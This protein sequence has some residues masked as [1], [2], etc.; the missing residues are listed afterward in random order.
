MRRAGPTLALYAAEGD[1]AQCAG[2][3]M[4]CAVAVA[5]RLDVPR[6]GTKRPVGMAEDG[7]GTV[8]AWLIL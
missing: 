6:V 2:A 5:G 7:R 1:G 8:N 3:D 4:E